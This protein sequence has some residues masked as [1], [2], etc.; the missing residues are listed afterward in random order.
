MDGTRVRDAAKL[1]ACFWIFI[2]GVV[3]LASPRRRE[4]T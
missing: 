3:A 1:K 2:A 4:S